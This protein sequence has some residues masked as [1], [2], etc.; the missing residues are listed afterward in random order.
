M[1]Q[2]EEILDEVCWNHGYINFQGL[3]DNLRH[4][5]ATG[6][7]ELFSIIEESA[8]EFSKDSEKYYD[9]NTELQDR[10]GELES[11]LHFLE[12]STG[13]LAKEILNYHS[14]VQDLKFDNN[15]LEGLNSELNDKIEYLR[16][17]VKELEDEL[18]ELRED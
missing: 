2:L 4:P 13:N 3:Q 15:N 12:D 5:T 7:K 8:R 18:N 6:H 17:R 16:D 14:L 11:E 1:R 9:T 10:V